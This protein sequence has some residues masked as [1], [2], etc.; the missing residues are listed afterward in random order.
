MT[1]SDVFSLAKRSEV[2]A[3]IRGK[4][5]EP[6]VR[7]RHALFALGLRYRLHVPDLPGRP[8]LVFPR[9]RAAVFINGCFWHG[10]GCDLF[11]W[12]K[13]NRAFWRSK[14]TGNAQRDRRVR[15][16][17]TRDGWRTLTIWECSIRRGRAHQI[18]AVASRV[19]RWLRVTA[20][21]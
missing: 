2:M 16:Q 11:K 6:E 19:E 15:R 12:P 1:R 14:I 10:H 18:P 17:L 9:Y 21:R 20:R 3:Q 4:N 13:N 5:T 7:L 8:D